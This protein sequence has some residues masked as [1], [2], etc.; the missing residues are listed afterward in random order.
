MRLDAASAGGFGGTVRFAT[1]D[2]TRNPFTFTI[3]GTPARPPRRWWWTTATPVFTATSGWQA[4]SGVG[5]GSDMRFKL[6]RRRLAGGR[7]GLHRPDGGVYRVWTTWVPFSNRVPDATYAVL[8]G[9]TTL[10]SATVDQRRRPR[11]SVTAAHRG[12]RLEA[13]SDSRAGR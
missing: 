10:G 2:P 7:L 11:A 12:S 4:Y 1:N 9:A 6:G 8:D 3:S 13:P 5:Y